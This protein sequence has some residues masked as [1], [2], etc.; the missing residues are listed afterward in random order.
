MDIACPNCAATYRVPDSLLASGKALRCAACDHEWVPEAPP[1]ES[2]VQDTPSHEARAPELAAAMPEEGPTMG[3]Q[4]A[5]DPDLAAP[6]AETPAG[7]MPVAAALSEPARPA[8]ARVSSPAAPPALQ[9][10]PAQMRGPRKP[11]AGRALPIAWLA[12]VTFVMLA[13][14]ALVLFGEEIALAWPPFARVTA[15]VSG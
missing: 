8:P 6:L 7:E 11:G 9:R 5:A 14:L 13:L 1:T 3:A 2:P 15:L 12:S 10:R 4:S